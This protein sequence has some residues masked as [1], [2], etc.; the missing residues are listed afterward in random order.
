M[1]EQ[2]TKA[3]IVIIEDDL[4][5]ANFLRDLLE[6][7]GYRVMSFA[8]GT[9]LAA[10]IVARPRLVLLDLMLPELDGAEICRRLRADP[11][12]RTTPIVM[13]TAASTTTIVQR[14]HGCA[15]DGLL[16]KPFDIDE[17]LGIATRYIRDPDAPAP[18]H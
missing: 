7:D 6:M 11:C 14:L 2:A 1:T 5:I 9:T 13:M 17:L 10:V 12:T 8:D 4:S 18:L 16:R 3:D 15:Y